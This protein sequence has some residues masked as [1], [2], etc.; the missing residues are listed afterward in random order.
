MADPFNDILIAGAGALG[1]ATAAELAARGCRVVVVD[2][3]VGNAS[4]VAAGMIAPA[5][6]ALLDG[7]DAARAAL[8]RDARDL[9]PAFAAR[10]GLTLYRELA[11]WRGP[12]AAERADRLEALGF[13]VERG[14]GVVATREDW[15]VDPLDSLHRLAATPGVRL[16]A[17]RVVRLEPVGDGWR[18]HGESGRSRDAHAVVLATGVG[19]AP[20]GTPPP[21]AG[22][23]ASIQ[24]IRGQ[25]AF[26]PQALT[27]R[28]VRGAGAYVAPATGGAVIGAT[29]EAGERA[30][31]VNR[32]AGD[33]QTATGLALVGATTTHEPQY[34]IGV[35]GASPDG[36]PMA[37][38]SSAP[39]LHL[40]LA[41]RRNGWLMAPLVAR[42]VADGIEGRD[43]GDHAATLNP[44]RFL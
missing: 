34:R 3:G 19:A 11:E 38:A 15:R 42:I 10:H 28:V 37:G 32:E 27:N 24:P 22:L 23:I 2:P 6:E 13:A 5:M 30:L 18:V 26:L 17:D 35:R 7:A 9:W 4:A 14:K 44:S 16:I 29:M 33:F 36:L 40:A 41:P 21:V 1:L 25:I 31:E 39:G 20:E 8:L 43:A 12:D